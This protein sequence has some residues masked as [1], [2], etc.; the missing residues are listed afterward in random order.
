MRK[1]VLLAM[2]IA[3]G[4]AGAAYAAT[5]QNVYVLKAKVSP[6]KAGTV[7]AG[8]QLEYTTSTIPKGQRPNVV[9][10]IKF[11]FAGVQAHPS[12]FKGCSTSRLNDPSEGP[13]TCPKGSQIGT[14]HFTALIGQSGNQSSSLPP[15]MAELTIYNGG[16][17]TVSFYVYVTKAQGQCP[18][19]QPV[20][21]A[22]SLHQS[23]TALTENVTIPASLRH[24]SLAGVNFD[25][26]STDVVLN[27]PA[28]TA[29]VHKKKVGLFE[30]FACPANHQR[31]IQAQFTLENGHKSSPVT[32]N[33]ACK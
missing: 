19:T 13:A 18:L 30:T 14:G 2:V 11:T 1:A 21:F 6:V 9:K 26:A 17:N 29:T 31:Q 10:S 32:R 23:K 4:A 28:K 7:P 12:A 33:V 22:A 15:C 24:A 8:I 27:I 5:I 20:A 16:G 25:I 3:L